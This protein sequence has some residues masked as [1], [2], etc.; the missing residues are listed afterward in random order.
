MSY[1]RLT[2]MKT[3]LA[4]SLGV[5][6]LSQSIFSLDLWACFLITSTRLDCLL[7]CIL[8]LRNKKHQGAHTL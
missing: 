7:Y 6:K 4:S 1:E 5:A 8:H 3:G 2:L